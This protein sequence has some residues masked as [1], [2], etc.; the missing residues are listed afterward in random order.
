M[1]SQPP[2]PLFYATFMPTY[3]PFDWY[4]TPVYYDLIF[5]AGTAQEA[6]FLEQCHTRH[7]TLRDAGA[8]RADRSAAASD[9]LSILEPACGSGRLM[10]EL[11]GRGHRVAGVDLSSGMLDFARKRFKKQR[12]SGTLLQA[13]MQN[14]DL[15]RAAARAGG[16]AGESKPGF[17]LA[18]ILVS[19]FKYLATEAD[20]AACL[21]CVCDHLRVGGVFVLGLH[22]TEADQTQRDLERWRVQR[23]H[24][25]VICTIRGAPPDHRRR[26]EQVRS[27]IVARDLRRPHAEPQR[28]ETNWTF[29]TYTPGQLRALLRRAP[30]LKHTA[31]YTFNHDTDERTRL[32]GDD[33]GVVLV[34]RR[35]R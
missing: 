20:A 22:T 6:R 2:R 31:T 3:E 13:P 18:H 4:Q 5:D 25:D 17:D 23:G 32:D 35:E 15:H 29:R 27:R 21:N 11:A 9:A 7:A 26:T 12:V 10:A 19:S 16:R 33:L 24:L 8:A 1:P 34:L 14:F 30:R 28:Y